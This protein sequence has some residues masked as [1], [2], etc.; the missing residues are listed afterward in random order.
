MNLAFVVVLRILEAM[1][2]IGAMGCVLTIP[3][4]AYKMFS[5]L[6]ERDSPEEEQSAAE[7]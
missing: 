7:R 1:F 2:L 5:V 3:V 4:A 6:V